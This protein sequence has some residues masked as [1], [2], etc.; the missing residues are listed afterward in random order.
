[1]TAH[2]G[3]REPE[4]SHTTFMHFAKR[5]ISVRAPNLLLDANSEASF[6]PCCLAFGQTYAYCF[7]EG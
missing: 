1:M 7:D 5:I 6:L 2:H 4:Q 3:V